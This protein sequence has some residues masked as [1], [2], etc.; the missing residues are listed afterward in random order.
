M[1]VVQVNKL[2]YPVIGGV[3]TVV[4][5]LMR[6]LPVDVERKVL[7]AS[8]DRKKKIEIID[9]YEVIKA[10]SIGTFK[11][12]PT[13]ITFPLYL[14]KLEKWADIF[15]FHF[16]FPPGEFSFL[17][18]NIKKPLVVTY[19]SDIVRQKMLLRLYRPFLDRFLDK[20]D[21]IISTSPNYIESSPF[22]LPRK[23]KCRAVPLGID[24]TQFELTEEL[25]NK[26]KEIKALYEPPL[27]LFVGRLIYYK[28]V[29]YLLKAMKDVIATL[30]IVGTGPLT[31][32]LIK[33]T[34]SLGIEKR[35]FFLPP[36][37]YS[38][39]VAMYHA[40][41]IFCLPSIERTEAFGIVQLEAQACGKPVVS[42][43]IGTGTSFANLDGTTGYVVLPKDEKSLA[44]A[45]N[46][47]ISDEQLREKLGEQAKKRVRE[48][49]DVRLMANKI[50]EIY[51]EVLKKT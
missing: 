28:G 42:T 22:L 29:E 45:L 14:K 6:F 38:D 3:E 19:H 1:K 7:V 49:F 51:L 2:Y 20:A 44:E 33:L 37:S 21:I 43:E 36:L 26:V 27:V 5:D 41:D 17:L 13:P 15:H 39:L 8:E 24:L 46:R 23:Q 50:Y 31:E 9:G 48:M 30:V 25:K 47:L 10:P 18:A 34:N 40:C 11:S 16:P 35:V 32:A 12:S 4:R